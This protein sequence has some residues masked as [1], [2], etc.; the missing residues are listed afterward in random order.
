MIK[1]LIWETEEH[2]LATVLQVALVVKDAS[3]SAEDTRDA[4][5]IPGWGRSPGEE[6]GNPPQYSCLENSTG[7]RSLAGYMGSQRVRHD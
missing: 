7:Q 2:M 5:S 6:D 1:H 4:G 3:A